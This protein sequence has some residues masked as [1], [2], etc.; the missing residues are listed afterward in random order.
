[1]TGW[2]LKST[3]I[4][5]STFSRGIAGPRY[6]LQKRTYIFWPHPASQPEKVIQYHLDATTLLKEKQSYLQLYKSF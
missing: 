4:S 1:M 6:L 5:N 2:S 3:F